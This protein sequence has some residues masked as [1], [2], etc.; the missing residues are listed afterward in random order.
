VEIDN[1]YNQSKQNAQHISIEDT[2]QVWNLEIQL[3]SPINQNF[4]TKIHKNR[5]VIDL[6]NIIK[7]RLECMD[8]QKI[9]NLKNL[10]FVCNGQEV[11]LQKKFAL[12]WCQSGQTNS[13][14]V[15]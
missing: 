1:M 14:R 6:K 5:K 11:D 13:E 15:I 10:N 4:F 12:V 3:M 9:S 8:V 2:S 7:D